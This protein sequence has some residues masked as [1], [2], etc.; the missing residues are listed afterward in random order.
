MSPATPQVQATHRYSIRQAAMLLEVSTRTVYRYIKADKI[1]VQY[2][3][4]D[5]KPFITGLEIMKV[6][7]QTY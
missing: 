3:S 5:S 2:R 7:N 1:A 4:I 6:W